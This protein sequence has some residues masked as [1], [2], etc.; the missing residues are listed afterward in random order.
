MTLEEAVIV[1]IGMMDEI[2]FAEAGKFWRV[3]QGHKD[4]P[5]EGDCLKQAAPCRPCVYQMLLKDGQRLLSL[6][7]EA[8]RTQGPSP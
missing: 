4:L 8:G 6:L 3:V 5:H 2:G 1:S 7:E